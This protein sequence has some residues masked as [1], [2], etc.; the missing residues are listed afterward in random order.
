MT[1]YDD[2][3]RYMPPGARI[4]SSDELPDDL[5]EALVIKALIGHR[6]ETAPPAAAAKVAATLVRLVHRNPGVEIHLGVGG[7]DED[8]REVIDIP[9]AL[10]VFRLFARKLADLPAADRSAVE[11]RLAEESRTILAL[12]TGRLRRGQIGISAPPGWDSRTVH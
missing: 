11:G 6:L 1:I 5:P 7:W 10:R 2:T 9:E 8:P 4:V 12:A 3:T